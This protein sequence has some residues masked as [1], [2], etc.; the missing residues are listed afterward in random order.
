MFLIFLSSL[1]FAQSEESK[2][3]GISGIYDFQTN[4]IGVGARMYIPIARIDRLALSPQIDYFPPS[5][6]V[7]E[8]YAG[9]SVQYTVMYIRNWNLYGL[10]AGYYNR[11]LNYQ[12]F[13]TKIAKQ[14]S[15]AGEVG[16]GLMRAIG[17]FHPFVEVR[18]DTRWREAHLEVGFL[19]SFG[20][21]FH[22]A[23]DL[24]PAYY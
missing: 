23:P 19:V 21:C 7:H 10:A 18:Y 17:C 12:K 2:S 14:N 9:L 15:F 11:W 24:C 22:H 8:L 5:N 20:D 4:G 1:T 16:G 13:D 3:Y 6:I